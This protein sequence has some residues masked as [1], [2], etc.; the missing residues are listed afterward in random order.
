MIRH[1]E[2]PDESAAVQLSH[3][4]RQK[5]S[6]AALAELSRQ[7]APPR[8]QRYVLLPHSEAAP[9]G[10]HQVEALD[11]EDGQIVV[12]ALAPT[13][14]GSGSEAEAGAES[15]EVRSRREWRWRVH[16]VRL[17]LSQRLLTVAVDH[18]KGRRIG[19]VPTI[20]LPAVR[21]IVADADLLH[22]TAAISLERHVRDADEASLRTAAAEI[23][24]AVLAAMSM[25][26]ATGYVDAAPGRLA[27]IV[28][29]LGQSVAT[30][31]EKSPERCNA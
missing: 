14:S 12:W 28:D 17:G 6:I 29:L 31:N 23:D 10:G 20:N 16:A 15:G 3:T 2:S 26:G 22:Q 25:L 5:G 21:L 13:Q 8:G 19:K 7:V 1:S 18:L 9:A 27:R 24:D 11:A 30:V 4:A